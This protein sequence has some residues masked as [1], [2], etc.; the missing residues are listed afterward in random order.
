MPPQTAHDAA[1]PTSPEAAT[2][3]EGFEGHHGFQRSALAAEVS[4]EGFTEIAFADCH[5]VVRDAVSYPLFLATCVRGPE[6]PAQ[7]SDL[8]PPASPAEVSAQFLK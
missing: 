4:V 5:H 6:Q 3:D 8:L 7:G 1:T 2:R